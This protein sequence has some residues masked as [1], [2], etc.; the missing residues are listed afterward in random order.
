[1]TVEKAPRYE[2]CYTHDALVR[3]PTQSPSCSQI[4]AEEEMEAEVVSSKKGSGRRRVGSKEKAEKAETP[5]VWSKPNPF[6]LV[7]TYCMGLQSVLKVSAF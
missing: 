7:Q 4:E 2:T 1:M 6:E 3:P 5:Y